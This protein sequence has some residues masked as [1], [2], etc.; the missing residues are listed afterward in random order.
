MLQSLS[1][2]CGVLG[3][4][5][6]TGIRPYGRNLPLAVRGVAA[7]LG[8]G[9][10]RVSSLVD[11]LLVGEAVV[12]GVARVRVAVVRRRRRPPAAV[13]VGARPEPAQH[14]GHVVPAAGAPP[15]ANP[16]LHWRVPVPPPRNTS[17]KGWH[18]Q[19]HTLAAQKEAKRRLQQRR[20][21]GVRKA[22][23]KLGIGNPATRLSGGRVSLRVAAQLRQQQGA[24]R[25]IQLHL[26]T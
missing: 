4:G 19:H 14:E 24:S 1:F 12:R 18:K 13:P 15:E 9:P 2:L 16:H 23:V 26:P 20:R 11:G 5:G 21:I 8:S 25:A 22:P 7:D 17:D 10:V 3:R 6:G